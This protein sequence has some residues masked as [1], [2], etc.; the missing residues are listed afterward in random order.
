M[1]KKIR[2][3]LEM[4]SGVEVRSL[5]ELKDNFSLSR[6]LEYVANGKLVTWLRDRYANDIADAVEQLKTDDND[7]PRRV[8]ELFEVPYDEQAEMNLQKAKERNEKLDKLIQYT[9]EQ[10]YLDAIDAVAFN[11]DDLYDLLDED[12]NRIYLCGDSF[13]IPLAKS[14]VSYHGINNP[15]V[16]FDSKGEVDW[17]EKD[18]ELEGVRFD[19]K[20]QNVINSAEKTKISLLEKAVTNVKQISS[21]ESTIVRIGDYVHDSYL[22]FLLSPADRESS[23]QSF[24]KVKTELETINYDINNDIRETKEMIIRNGLVGVADNY[25]GRL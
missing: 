16:D 15:V 8:S 25:I 23:E 22:N 6:V 19:E 17:K 24:C 7:L 13:F 10:K 14:G 5:A 11:Q 20:Y 12:M 2:F 4:E 18:I 21:S 1:S 3:P 9:T